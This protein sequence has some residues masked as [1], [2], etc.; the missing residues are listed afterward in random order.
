[1][2]NSMFMRSVPR[3]RM[4]EMERWYWRA[5]CSPS[6]ACLT[7]R[8]SGLEVT[9]SKIGESGMR[10]ELERMSFAKLLP[11]FTDS[12]RTLMTR[13]TQIDQFC[14]LLVSSIFQRIWARFSDVYWY[15]GKFHDVVKVQQTKRA[16]ER[17]SSERSSFWS[18]LEF[19]RWVWNAEWEHLVNDAK[20]HSALLEICRTHWKQAFRSFGS[21]YNFFAVE[22]VETSQNPDPL[23]AS[24]AWLSKRLAQLST[25][26]DKQS[27]EDKA[28]WC[29]K[30]LSRKTKD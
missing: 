6:S 30:A 19:R 3:L 15:R 2:L 4:F 9:T 1:M 26:P 10:V 8:E 7:T 17:I 20:Q 29:S 13:E 14:S 22:H 11:N 28:F 27:H 21:L 16:S 12:W 24:R 25:Q 23:C 5:N 18:F